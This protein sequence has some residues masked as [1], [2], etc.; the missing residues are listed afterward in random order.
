ME[1]DEE[2]DGVVGLTVNIPDRMSLWS[3]KTRK[4]CCP[5]RPGLGATG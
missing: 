5:Q 1:P 3:H 4:S 2:A